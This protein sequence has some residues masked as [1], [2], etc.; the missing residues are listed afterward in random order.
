MTFA[1]RVQTL[2][3][4]YAVWRKYCGVSKTPKDFHA[5]M[6]ITRHSFSDIMSFLPRFKSH[7]GELKIL[8][9]N[10]FTQ[11]KIKK[12]ISVIPAYATHAEIQYTAPCVDW[13]NIV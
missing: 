1:C 4:N 10:L 7:K 12:L 6:T 13:E 5:F 8:F 9:K 2:K 11:R 3:E